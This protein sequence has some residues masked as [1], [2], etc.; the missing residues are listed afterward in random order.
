MAR[1]I[2]TSRREAI[3][4]TQDTLKTTRPIAEGV[5]NAMLA[6][7]GAV[8]NES[9]YILFEDEEEMQKQKFAVAMTMSNQHSINIAARRQNRHRS[10]NARRVPLDWNTVHSAAQDEEKAKAALAVIAAAMADPKEYK[11]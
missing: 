7:K 8:L 11:K 1:H 2:G 3:N 9:G 4:W 5:F 10:T 6:C